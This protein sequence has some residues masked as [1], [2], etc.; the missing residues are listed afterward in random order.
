MNIKETG[1]LVEGRSFSYETQLF[2]VA[3]PNGIISKIHDSKLSKE[4]TPEKVKE[5]LRLR[6]KK[7]N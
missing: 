2:E 3:S 6:N 4:V 5:F 1:E 7:S